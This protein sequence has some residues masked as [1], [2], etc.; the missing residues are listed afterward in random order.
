MGA[1][2]IINDL[3]TCTPGSGTLM[4]LEQDS[5][6]PTKGD[7]LYPDNEIIYL[8]PDGTVE[9][10]SGDRYDIPQHE[11]G[12]KLDLGKT[13]LGLVLGGFPRALEE[14]GKIGTFGAKK[15]T[16]NG[17]MSVPQGIERYTD[18]MLRHVLAEFK[19]ET[20]DHDSGLLVAAHTAW[21]A[22]ARLELTLKEIE[23]K[24]NATK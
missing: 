11:P 23:R 18:A 20:L 5:A 19:G 7:N 13:R 3:S 9:K 2:L 16:D 24:S 17:W 10:R 15:Y 14:V 6:F 22:L 21:N 8:N 12:A 4:I 1:V